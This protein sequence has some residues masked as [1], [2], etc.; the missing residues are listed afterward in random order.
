M[1]KI[2]NNVKFSSLYVDYTSKNG[3]NKEEDEIK[4]KRLIEFLINKKTEIEN[5]NE[6]NGENEDNKKIKLKNRR[7]R[8]NI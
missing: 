8:N 2:R 4:K 7:K 3:I 5:N 6:E 1:E